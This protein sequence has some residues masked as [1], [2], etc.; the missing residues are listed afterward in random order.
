[1]AAR[2]AAVLRLACLTAAAAAAAAAGPGPGCSP[3]HYRALPLLFP[4]GGGNASL[5][6]DLEPYP[7]V[8]HV[9]TLCGSLTSLRLELSA[10]EDADLQLW[11]EGGPVMGKDT[12][13]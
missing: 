13:E 3:S 4:C 2:R 9:A 6:L 7:Q 10:A 11:R 1:M 5:T 12:N 8:T